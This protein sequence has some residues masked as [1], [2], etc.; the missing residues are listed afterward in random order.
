M[1]RNILIIKQVEQEGPG[2]IEELFAAH[3]WGIK[4]I[5]LSRNEKLPADFDGTGA[6]VVLGGPM[7][8]YEEKE[9]P[10][11]KGEELLIRKALIEEV[12]LLGICLG[13]QL[14]AK[15][16]GARV[17]KAQEKEVGWYTVKKTEEGKKDQLFSGS[18]DQMRVFQWHEDTF[19]LPEGA[20]LLAE[21]K[22]CRNQAFRVG[23][24]AYGF[25]FHV[26][27]TE[28]MVQRWFQSE[29]K[30]IG[31]KLLRDMKKAEESYREQAKGL[32][33]NFMHI[34]ESSL[35]LRQVIKLFTQEG[36]ASKK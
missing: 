18:S 16:C 15:T 31:E 32:L 24:S 26:E 28:E 21:G 9:Y 27:V 11:L 3:S 7:N 6:L 12:P 33:I 22:G 17:R 19:D 10:F 4:T 29:E 34:A 36:R 13:A 30:S 5:E 25:Q 14:L 2:L 35:K 23:Q 8:V 1:E 20:V